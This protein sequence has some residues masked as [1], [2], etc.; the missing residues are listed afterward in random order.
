MDSVGQTGCL[1][2]VR[3]PITILI[4]KYDFRLREWGAGIVNHRDDEILFGGGRIPLNVLAV[5]VGETADFNIG[6]SRDH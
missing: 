3:G 4:T 6:D 1:V 2:N 5:S